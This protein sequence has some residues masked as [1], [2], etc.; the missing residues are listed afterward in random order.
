MKYYLFK[1]LNNKTAKKELI[2]HGLQDLYELKDQVTKE[3]FIGGRCSHPLKN[4][5]SSLLVE[6]KK[7]SV[8]WEEQWA[9]FAENFSE[10]KAHIDLSRFGKKTILELAPG[11]GFGDLSHP[12]TALMLEMMQG[13]VEN[14]NVL[15]IG[16]GSGILALAALLLGAKSAIGLDID[17][18]ALAHARKNSKLNHL[19]VQFL[20]KL[21]RHTKPPQVCLLNMILPE[22][23]IALQDLKGYNSL[24]Q[25]WITS[26]ILKNQ[27]REYLS[28][29]KSWG[30]KLEAS[31]S[32]TTW[33]GFV[34]SL[35]K[36]S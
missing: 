34:F 30:W 17:P 18:K 13:R 27:K 15:D 12:T 5:K 32:K 2:S 31:Y 11:P 19:S 8:D 35:N 25:L 1:V 33:L 36:T 6:E 16:T 3:V 24:A 20:K 4:L 29:T 9:L 28:L 26:G 10:G 14:E 21:P 7:G 22:Q 23:K